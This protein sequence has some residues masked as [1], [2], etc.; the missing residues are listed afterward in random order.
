MYN[1]LAFSILML[2]LELTNALGYVNMFIVGTSC[3]LFAIFLTVA[4]MFF[5][6]VH[7]VIHPSKEDRKAMAVACII[8]SSSSSST[9]TTD[10]TDSSTTEL[11]S[12][13]SKLYD[14]NTEANH[15]KQKYLNE[16][17][18]VSLLQHQLVNLAPGYLSCPVTPPPNPPCSSLV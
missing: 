1:L 4:V 11:A 16:V 10:S 12:L 7:S 18:R 6:K 15:W 2:G 8:R 14:A 9:G 17:Q 5:P 13:H 3:L